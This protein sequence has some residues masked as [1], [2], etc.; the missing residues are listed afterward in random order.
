[1]LLI[2]RAVQRFS[3]ACVG[4]RC[5]MDWLQHGIQSGPQLL[6]VTLTVKVPL[7][8]GLSGSIPNTSHRQSSPPHIEHSSALHSPTTRA[9][10]PIGATHFLVSTATRPT[11]PARPAHRP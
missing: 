9:P 7:R 1:M 4:K 11:R 6:S 3:A 8:G 5:G 10:T 2:Q